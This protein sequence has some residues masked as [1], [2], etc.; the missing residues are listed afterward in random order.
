M[1]KLHMP[2]SCGRVMASIT[3]LTPASTTQIVCRIITSDFSKNI[4][5]ISAVDDSECVPS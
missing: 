2:V 4:Q 3:A 1:V 5:L